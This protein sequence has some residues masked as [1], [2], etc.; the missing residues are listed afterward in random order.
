MSN[1]LGTLVFLGVILCLIWLYAEVLIGPLF[2]KILKSFGRDTSKYNLIEAIIL[3]CAV[4][5]A[6]GGTMGLMVK[7]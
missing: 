4:L 6:V 7:F 5:I 3:Y 1:L 2:E